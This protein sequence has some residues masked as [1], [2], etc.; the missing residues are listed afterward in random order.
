LPVPVE[1]RFIL[2]NAGGEVLPGPQEVIDV[3]Q[4]L[5]AGVGLD[6]LVMGQPVGEAQPC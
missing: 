2:R 4:R 1:F 5:L 6:A 3:L